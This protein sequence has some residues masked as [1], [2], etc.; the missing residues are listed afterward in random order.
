MILALANL[1]TSTARNILTWSRRL[2]IRISVKPPETVRKVIVIGNGTPDD[3]VTLVLAHHVDGRE[4]ATILKPQKLRV[5]SITS[6]VELLLYAPR[7]NK[8]LL[9]IDQEEDELTNIRLKIRRK[10]EL[11]GVKIKE[12]RSNRRLLTYKCEKI[13]LFNL[14]VAVNGLD[15]PYEIHTIEDH[16]L[17][18]AKD[19]VKTRIV[20]PKKTWNEI[21]EYHEEIIR[22]VRDDRDLA[23]SLF[24]QQIK[25]LEM[26]CE[27][28]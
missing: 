19:F 13:R 14:L 26:L 18:V 9:I 25:A 10:L 7:I 2:K 15:K 6:I 12:E 17:E 5:E 23:Y 16:L 24:P 20:N 27:D 1:S 28:I 22:R 3:I 11:N 8:I 4:M 21:K